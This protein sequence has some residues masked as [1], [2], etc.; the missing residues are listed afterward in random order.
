V[1]ANARAAAEAAG[2]PGDAIAELWDRLVEASIAYELAAFD[3]R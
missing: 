2:L 1:I 3:R